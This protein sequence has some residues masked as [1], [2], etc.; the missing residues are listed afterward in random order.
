MKQFGILI[1]S[2][3]LALLILNFV[4]AFLEI[5]AEANW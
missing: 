4:L 1:L 3:A 2:I 5:G